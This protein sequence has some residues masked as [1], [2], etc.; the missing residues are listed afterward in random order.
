MKIIQLPVLSDNFAYVVIDERNSNC[1]FIDTPDA[2]RLVECVETEGL[3]PVAILNT[4]H[5]W[6]HVDG[7]EPL[8]AKYG[9]PIYGSLYDAKRI[10]GLT[11]V[12]SEGDVLEFGSLKF[13]VIEAPGHTLG[14]VA[15]RIEYNLFCGDT[16]FV[17]GCGR[18]FEGTA[19]QMQNSLNKLCQLPDIT[20]IY[21]AHEY[22]LKNL[23]FALTL[24]PELTV[25]KNKMTEV[26]IKLSQ[27]LATV[28]ST[29]A[30]EKSYNPFL[31]WMNP[32]LRALAEEQ[33]GKTLTEDWQIFAELR[34]LKDHYV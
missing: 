34:K 3:N 23:Q 24:E 10:P 15:Y 33:A 32:S 14:H 16:I 27:G 21:C 20:K 22:T 29:L 13:E 7:N 11:H 17:G 12:V 5:H 26:Q 19:Q 31:R 1:V 28:P 2:V 6:D 8:R 4:H 25:L 30:E 9:V 18:L